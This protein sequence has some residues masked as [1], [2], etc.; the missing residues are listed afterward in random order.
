MGK[1]VEMT[2][3][4]VLLSTKHQS[5]IDVE[6]PLKHVLRKAAQA[7]DLVLVTCLAGMVVMVF[8]NVVLR[9]G[10]DTGLVFSEEASRY[11]FV[12]MIFLGAV[13]AMHE[14]LHIGMDGLVRR[15]SPRGRLACFVVSSLLMLACCALLLV[16]G[17]QQTALNWDVM[18]Q[19]SGVP[20]AAVYGSLVVSALGLGAVIL[21]QLT[22]AL[23]SGR[24]PE[25][26]AGEMS[27][28]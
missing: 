18:A 20:M 16:G 12:W 10:F 17:W 2:N 28:D 19:V 24:A 15:L 6:E 4:N 13:V 25:P 26:P 5:T 3:K 14:H 1:Q 7:T 27:L 23:R 22:H 11:L 9:Y 21:A 8:A